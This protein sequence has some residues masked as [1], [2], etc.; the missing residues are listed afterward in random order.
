LVEPQEPDAFIAK[1]VVDVDLKLL[2]AASSRKND[3][4]PYMPASSFGFRLPRRNSVKAGHSFVIR[5]L[6]FAISVN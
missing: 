4:R 2:G 3:E 5:H 6:R 1:R